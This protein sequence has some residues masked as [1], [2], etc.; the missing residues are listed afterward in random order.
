MTTGPV[1]SRPNAGQYPSERRDADRVVLAGEADRPV[2]AAEHLKRRLVDGA[3]GAAT[4][5]RPRCRC[6]ARARSR[7]VLTVDDPPC[8]GP[9]RT[10][11]GRTRPVHGCA[12]QLGAVRAHRQPTEP[13]GQGLLG[14]GRERPPPVPDPPDHRRRRLPGR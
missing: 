11:T 4:R 13:V 9:P 7:T 1:V 6:P 3:G 5:T 10:R 8:N 14:R 2:S 12:N